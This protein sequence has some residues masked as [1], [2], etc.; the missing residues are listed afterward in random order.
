MIIMTDEAVSEDMTMIMIDLVT[1]VAVVLMMIMIDVDI[2]TMMMMSSINVKTI[3][4]RTMT[5]NQ[6]LSVA[7]PVTMIVTVPIWTPNLLAKKGMQVNQEQQKKQAKHPQRK[8][9]AQHN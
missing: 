6:Q 9:E 7:H 8:K 2:V 4:I 3:M 5:K 1:D